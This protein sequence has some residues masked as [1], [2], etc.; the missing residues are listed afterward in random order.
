MDKLEARE[1]DQFEFDIEESDPFLRATITLDRTVNSRN[2]KGPVYAEVNLS[3]STTKSKQLEQKKKERLRTEAR[4]L[5]MRSLRYTSRGVFF[6]GGLG[7][8]LIALSRF[9]VMTNASVHEVLV[10]ACYL[11]LSL[12]IG[13]TQFEY[14]FVL[15]YCL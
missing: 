13:F 3:E 9:S 14:T 5:W 12:F 6:A 11:V 15:N 1:G 7:L 8:L 4:L 2:E 10:N